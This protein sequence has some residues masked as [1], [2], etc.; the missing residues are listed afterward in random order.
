MPNIIII[1]LI[2]AKI[3]IKYNLSYLFDN[4]EIGEFMNEKYF[5]HFDYFNLKSGNGLHMVEKFESGIQELANSCAPVC[6]KLILNFYGK[7]LTQSESELCEIFNS[8]PY[9]YGTKLCDL[10]KGVEKVCDNKTISSLE[11]SKKGS[12]RFNTF[13]EFKEFVLHYIDKQIPIIVENV[14]YGGHYKI[15]IGYDEVSDVEEEDVLIF[16]DPSDFNDGREDGYNY[17]PAERF[18]YMWFDSN[19]LAEEERLQPFVIILP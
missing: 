15:L 6:V 17:F 3:L 1:C 7:K 14:D 5:K 12:K 10:L 19:C 9:P 11:S 2:Y 8:R 18:F 16:A 13:K 4:I